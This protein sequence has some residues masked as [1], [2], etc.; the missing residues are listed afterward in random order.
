MSG[1]SEDKTTPEIEIET[2]I[3]QEQEIQQHIRVRGNIVT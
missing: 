1:Q 2:E 3:E